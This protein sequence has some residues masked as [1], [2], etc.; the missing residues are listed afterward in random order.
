ME[1]LLMAGEKHETFTE[2][3]P[4]RLRGKLIRAACTCGWASSK[5]WPEHAVQ[6]AECDGHEHEGA[7]AENEM[8]ARAKEILG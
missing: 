8:I 3:Y 7:M 5:G 6:P 4:S 2:L 1:S